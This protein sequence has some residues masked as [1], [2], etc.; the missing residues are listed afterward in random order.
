M[1]ARRQSRAGNKPA[2]ITG[3]EQGRVTFENI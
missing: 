1:G 3:D 2:D